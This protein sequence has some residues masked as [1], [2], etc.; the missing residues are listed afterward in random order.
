MHVVTG[1]ASQ[2]VVRDSNSRNRLRRSCRDL[3]YFYLPSIKPLCQPRNH[4]ITSLYNWPPIRTDSRPWRMFRLA[5][6]F[7]CLLQMLGA[8]DI[9]QVAHRIR[10]RFRP[11]KLLCAG[12]AYLVVYVLARVNNSFRK[13]YLA[14]SFVALDDLLP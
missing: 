14:Q 8:A 10:L 6:F 13:A 4:A 12:F 3:A 2:T 7:L 5:L 11:S 9:P 1:Y